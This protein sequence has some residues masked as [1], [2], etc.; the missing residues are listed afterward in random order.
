M[1]QVQNTKKPLIYATSQDFCRIFHE[2]MNSLY[3][4]SLLLTADEGKAERCYVHGLE[5]CADG[6]PVFKE[7][8]HSWARRTIVQ[9]A[10]RMIAPR[11]D[12]REIGN[13]GPARNVA[14]SFALASLLEL[15]AFD[16]FAY[17]LS[18]LE[19]YSDHDCSLLLGC[20][21]QDVV[22]G[23]SRASQHLASTGNVDPLPGRSLQAGA[24]AAH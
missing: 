22:N 4:L 13:N 8:A 17:V 23:R 10:I 19:K 3:L 11:T 6:G 1:S 21:H 12:T 9:N 20:S 7:W 2:N 5:D 24:A 15:K 14:A 16:R 18:V